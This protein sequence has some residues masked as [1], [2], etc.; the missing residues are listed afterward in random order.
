L[1]AQVYVINELLR[2]RNSAKT[3]ISHFELIDTF[4]PPKQNL[5]N[6]F[7]KKLYLAAILFFSFIGTRA[8]ITINEYSCSNLTQF[9]DDHSD[10][11]DWMELYNAGS[12]SVILTGYYLS[13][14]SLLPMKWKIP[15]GQTISANGFK[16]F[17]CDGRD[18]STSTNPHTNFKLTQT[19]G[20]AEYIVF[21]DISGNIIDC[22]NLNST[23]RTQLGHSR[24]RYPNGSANWYIYTTPNPN[25]TN[26]SG[27]YT[28]YAAKPTFDVAAGFYP[29]TV[30]VTI[31]NT[32]P[33]STCYYTTSGNLPTTASAVYS[34]P[35]SITATK[36]L[37]AYVVSTNP[38]ILPGFIEF[39]TY[40]INEPHT[41]SVVSISGTSLTT[42][43][44]GSGTLTPYGTFEYFDVNGVRKAKSYGEFNRHGQDSWANSQR[45]LDY[46]TRDEMGYNYHIKEQ[47]FPCTPRDSYQRVILRAA[48]DD[49]FP[50]DY[51]TSNLGS[52]HV[53]DAYVE[54][55]AWSTGMDLDVRLS[56]KT[57]VFI[58]G[59][60]WGVYDIRDN[61]D[62]H[63]NTDYYYGQD[64]YHL[65][66]IETWGN[67]WAQ[68]GGNQALTDWS[69][70]RSFILNNSMTNQANFNHVDSFLD[71]K[72]LSDYVILNSMVVCTDWLNYNSGWWRGMDTTGTHRKWGYILW[73]NDAVF[74]FYINYT[75]VPST[76]YNA[77]P[78]NPQTMINS[79]SD[80]EQ[81]LTV[82]AKLLT[83]SGFQTWYR[84]RLIDLWNTTFSC[85]TMLYKLDSVVAVIAPEMPRHC[86]RWAGNMTDWQ[87]NVNTLRTFISNRCNWM[88]TGLMNCYSL[89]GP[90][91]LKLNDDPPSAGSIDLNSLHF[92]PGQLPWQGTYFGNITTSLTATAEPNYAFYNW[93]DNSQI[94]NPNMT[95]AAVTSNFNASDSIVAHFNIVT[96]IGNYPGVEISASAYPTVFSGETTLEYTLPKHLPVTFKLTNL[97]GEE[98]TTINTPTQYQD[99]GAYSVKLN[100]SNTSLRSGIYLLQ[101]TAGDYHKTIKLVYTGK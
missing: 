47:L 36:I 73:D 96:S 13:D 31:T 42:L 99:R 12:S 79:Y 19:K 90:Y 98:V 59:Q 8:Q 43:A 17:W 75:G 38:A 45:S 37:K 24:G 65:Q 57:L 7:M 63:D 86:T 74:D 33:T 5:T 26:A 16:R 71:V 81:H 35:V 34:T 48:G 2:G 100:L 95:T 50:A 44:N 18:S 49:N 92:T 93:T 101:F 83:N 10:Y 51:H 22:I 9:V 29:S 78:C 46:I 40:F 30:L 66:F 56:V 3:S 82:L 72:S 55:L 52:A 6:R 28:A 15:S 87:N 54:M 94:L 20:T 39:S 23:H 76:Q 53:R 69:T 11:N 68:Y 1:R 64:K 91:T 97:L 60:Y 61:P 14:D 80:P 67:T 62:D 27:V 4:V 88:A 85:D 32:E 58:N 77:P 84:N 25:A 21:S 41:M 89:T 70:L